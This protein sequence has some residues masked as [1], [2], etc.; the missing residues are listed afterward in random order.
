MKYFLPWKSVLVG[1]GSKVLNILY[2]VAFSY[3]CNISKF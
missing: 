2:M 3:P 1:H